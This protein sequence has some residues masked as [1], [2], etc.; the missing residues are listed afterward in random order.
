MKML[1]RLYIG[2]YESPEHRIVGTKNFSFDEITYAFFKKE[3]SNAWP[4][5]S[6]TSLTRRRSKS[7]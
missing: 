7:S 5:E 4:T 1:G 2:T 3:V 6:G